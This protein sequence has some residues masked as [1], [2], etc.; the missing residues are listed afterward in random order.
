MSGRAGGVLKWER[1]GEKNLYSVFY[2]VQECVTYLSALPLAGGRVRGDR[3]LK[4]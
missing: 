2:R 1:G 4:N 3:E